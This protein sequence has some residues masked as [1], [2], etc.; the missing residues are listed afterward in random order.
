MKFNLQNLNDTALKSYLLYASIGGL[1]TYIFPLSRFVF[2]LILLLLFLRFL[3]IG[4]AKG[5]FLFIFFIITY[6][7]YSFLFND[8][9]YIFYGVYVFYAFLFSFSFRRGY[10]YKISSDFKFWLI[11]Y[12]VNCFG[13]IV[14]N[15][16][17]PI[18]VGLEQD[19]MG[20]SK[21]VAR[22]WGTL[23]LFRNPGFTNASVTVASLIAISAISIQELL[24]GKRNKLFIFLVIPIFGFSIYCLYL[25]TTKTI[26]YSYLFVSIIRFLPVLILKIFSIFLTLFTI[27]FVYYY[28][29][30]SSV[31]FSDTENSLLIRMEYTWPWSFSLL[32]GVQNIFGGGFGKVGSA[33]YLKGDGVPGD[34]LFVY[35]YMIFGVFSILLLLFFI[36]HFLKNI[37]RSN[38]NKVFLAY[39]MMVVLFGF[40]NNLI[41][42]IIFPVFFGIIIKEFYM[43]SKVE[44]SV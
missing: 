10:F 30:F 12:L 2:P 33:S 32:T 14:V 41:E 39:F 22:E 43:S 13:I 35:L 21:Q 9:F 26:M 40:T 16:E 44:Y 29:F 34:N 8:T 23:G 7:V 42:S 27:I 5:K 24:I 15:Y 1:L 11:I 28:Y 17:R 4:E 25:S 37:F 31:I 3:V 36:F 19:L 20:I 18:W 6:V 38:L